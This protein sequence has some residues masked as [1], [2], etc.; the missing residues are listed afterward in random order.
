M[1]RL[2]KVANVDAKTA[3]IVTRDIISKS[4]GR[5]TVYDLAGHSEFYAS[6][7]TALRNALAGSPSSIIVLVADMR[8]GSNLFEA[9]IL[10]WCSFAENLYEESTD[11]LPFLI[12]VG[13]HEDSTSKAITFACGQVIS[14]LQESSSLLAFLLKALC[15]LTV[16]T[17][18]LLIWKNYVPS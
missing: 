4:L 9:A 16:D 18:C 8:G 6:H 13:S 1:N 17:L 7:D 11:N 5:V 15:P 2:R 3:G 14:G 12:I 10:K